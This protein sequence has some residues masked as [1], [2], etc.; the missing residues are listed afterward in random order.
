MLSWFAIL[1]LLSSFVAGGADVRRA[2]AGIL[3]AVQSADRRLEARTTRVRRIQGVITRQAGMTYHAAAPGG[4]GK[5]ENSG[6]PEGAENAVPPGEGETGE[7]TMAGMEEPVEATP[8]EPFDGGKML[9][10]LP[11]E[12]DQREYVWGP[13]YVDELAFQFDKGRG[14]TVR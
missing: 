7:V 9:A 8:L 1:A 3:P 5:G 12:W 11:A 6:V 2:C 14:G 10:A 13:D 4:G